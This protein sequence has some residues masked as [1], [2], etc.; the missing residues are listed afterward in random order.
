MIFAK[1]LKLYEMNKKIIL[2]ILSVVLIAGSAFFLSGCG[3]D[4][5]QG[6]ISINKRGAPSLAL[7]LDATTPPDDIV[8]MGTRGVAISKFKLAATGDD[9]SVKKLQV[10]NR[11]DSQPGD[12]D[13]N[14]EKVTLIYTDSAGHSQEKSSMLANGVANFAGLDLFTAKDNSVTFSVA[15]TINTEDGGSLSGQMIALDVNTIDEALALNANQPFNNLNFPAHD[16]GFMH[17][18]KTKP[19]IS[20]SPN[21]PSGSKTQAVF[22]NILAFDIAANQ[23]GVVQIGKIGVTL[24]SNANFDMKPVKATLKQDFATVST[25]EVNYTN[26]SN[27]Y[28]SF[29]AQ[30]GLFQIPAGNSSQFEVYLSTNDLLN[31]NAGVDDPLTPSVNLGSSQKGQ[32]TMGDIIWTD[33]TNAA[34]KALWLG[35]QSNFSLT[36]NTLKY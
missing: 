15:A 6:R 35:N 5:L 24:N 25:A 8:V 29:P 26:A 13:N 7:L 36:G 23:G 2:P 14:I 31:I 20:L 34:P 16:V 19:S 9:F 1:Y 12:V 10:S 27:A 30:N 28:I 32:V 11:F 17:V 3:G 18:Y 4:G 33:D 21:S 22:D